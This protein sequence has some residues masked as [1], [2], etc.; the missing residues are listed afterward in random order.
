ME[1]HYVVSDYYAT[2][3]GRTISILITPGYIW[4]GDYETKPEYI[5]KED[6]TYS[7][8]EGVL[9][10]SMNFILLREFAT[11]FDWF[12]YQGAEI[13]TKEDFLQRYGK[14]VSSYILDLLESKAGNLNY[15]NQFHI[16][17]S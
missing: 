9:K 13:L 15:Y 5:K 12:H 2:G 1:L 14:Y 3:E 16:N 4:D 6:G 10:R 8:K 7:F 17:L 11:I